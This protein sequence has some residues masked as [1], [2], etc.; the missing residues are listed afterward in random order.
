ML[1]GNALNITLINPTVVLSIVSEQ[2]AEIS[3]QFNQITKLNSGDLLNCSG[4]IE[5][6]ET[7]SRL[8]ATFRSVQLKKIVRSEKKSAENVTDEKFGLLFQSHFSIGD[9]ELNVYIA[10]LSMPIVVIVHGNQ[11]PQSHATILWDNAFS[12]LSRRPF[13]V[14]SFTVWKYLGNAL[15]MKFCA[16]THSTDVAPNAE[17]FTDNMLQCLCKKA[18][19]H[20][21]QRDG[22]DIITWA[23]F[24]KD[25]L[26]DRNF[27]FWEWFYAAMRLIR[28]HMCDLWNKNYIFGF[29]D[30]ASAENLLLTNC[31]PGTF[32]LRFSDSEL[33]GLTIAT[34][35]LDE[36][37]IPYV[38]HIQPLTSKVLTFHSLPDRIL[39]LVELKTLYPGI[40]KADAFGPYASHRGPPASGYVPIFVHASLPRPS[41]NENQEDSLTLN[42]N[43]SS[44]N[45]STSPSTPGTASSFSIQLPDF[46][47]FLT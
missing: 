44:M 14:E 8:A 45:S 15:R 43:L 22:M 19:R 16:P 25:P 18:L 29:I 2:Q 17:I 7:T 40:K 30:K 41:A 21:I 47:V 26:P 27:T 46:N 42:V 37:N 11:E 28:E 36:N 32:L 23:Q 13:D 4:G 35:N 9:G 34:L 12:N 39:D 20:I 33:G 5:L 3:Q 38:F 31:Q 1:I 10:A 6:N 24:C